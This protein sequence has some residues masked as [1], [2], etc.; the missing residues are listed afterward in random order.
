MNTNQLKKFAKAARIRLLGDVKNRFLYWGIAKDGTV[1]HQVDTT[2]G[3]YEFRGNVFNDESVPKKWDKLLSAVK[4]HPPN[5]IIEEAAYTWF[6]RLISIKILEEN[7]YDDPIIS[8]VSSDLH[9]P[10]ILR[11]AKRG[12]TPDMSEQSKR[13]LD[14]YIND[15]NDDEALSLLLI[16]YCKNHKLLNRLFGRIDDYTELL[17]PNNLLAKDGIIS[18]IN[19]TDYITEEDFQQV[20]LIG[21]LYQFYISDK[22]DDVF[23]SFKKKQKARAE[24]IPAATQIFTPKWIV[25]YLI[26]NTVGR[27]WLDKHSDS[28]I[29]NTMKYLVEPE[30]AKP[31]EP[32]IDNVSELKVLDPA[33]GSGHFLVVAFDLLMQAYKEEGYTNRYAVES[34]IK[35]NL[36]GL[37]LCKRAVGL[38]NFAILLKG[39]SYYPEILQKDV[40]QHIFAMP[41]Q[42]EFSKQQVFDFLGEEGR[43]YVD[44]LETALE[45]MQLAQ[46]IGS[47]LVIELSNDT[48]EFIQNRFGDFTRR[49]I[50]NEF[51]LFE[52]S[53]F[54]NIKSFIQ[55]IL[56][57]TDKYPAVV[58]NPP[59]M[60]SKNMNIELSDYL[61]SHYPKSKA[62]LFAVFM[63]VLPN[64]TL[65]GGGFGFIT[66]PSW[67]FLITYGKLREHYL[68]NYY[69]KSLLHLSRGVFGAD[70]GAVATALEK[71]PS[72]NRTGDYLRLIERT[73]QEFETEHLH[74]LLSNVLNNH[75]FK[76]DFGKYT[77][78]SGIPTQS[79]P[80]GKQIYYTQIP[81]TNFSKIPGSPIAYWVSERVIE[82][83]DNKS[84]N[85]FVET[86]LGMATGSNKIFLRDWSEVD[87]TKINLNCDNRVS[88]IESEKKWY[89]YSKG[90]QYRKWYGNQE[91]LVNWQNDGKDLRNFATSTGRIRSHNYNLDYIFKNGITW[92][93]LSSG[94]PSMR[95]LNSSLF[96]NAG[97]SLFSDSVSRNVL[98]GYLNTNLIP[99]FQNI[100]SSTFNYQ[101]GDIAKLPYKPILNSKNIDVVVGSSINLSKSDWDSRETSWDFKKLPLLNNS[102]SLPKSY[103]SWEEKVTEDFFKL[104]E[105]EEE[106]NRIFIDIYALQDEL[107][108]DVALKDITILQE[109]LD[110][111]QLKIDNGK[112]IMDSSTTLT[113]QRKLPIKKDVVIKQLLS[114]ATGCFMGRYRL[115]KPGLNIAH[116]NPSSEELSS[117]THN[118]NQ[119]EIDDDGII[120][121]MGSESP[122][123][124]DI[125]FRTKEF[126]RM[127]WSD[128]SFTEN[129]NFINECLGEDLEKYLTKKF[130]NDHKKTYKKKPIYWQFSSPQD[131]FKVICYMHRMNRFTVQ[132]IRQNYLFKQINWYE[133]EISQLSKNEA[134]LTSKES[135]Q[136]D[137]F[138]K[139]LVEC[140]EYDLLLKD[141]ADKQIEF[142]LD[143]GV[144]ENYKL[145]DGVVSK[146]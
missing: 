55:S 10:I 120:P 33:V 122:F 17:L 114:Y 144:T 125:V 102:S 127:V 70:F 2:S 42:F 85:E 104:H 24:D 116:P 88:A 141:A 145:F 35:N 63:E 77:K 49:E 136:L 52:A 78:E 123:A 101:P 133:R 27:I 4:L 22:K 81:Q 13:Q 56:I 142:D 92:N 129:L 75:D 121:T 106:L 21:W 48:R 32:I 45:Q 3:G 110:R 96:D 137:N 1:I 59:Y 99:L 126:V 46:N 53:L 67:M 80:N 98:L 41:E 134:R 28:P 19:N 112:L 26:E 132:K 71:N 74:Q 62:D 146:I 89:P 139:N 40:A 83:F 18:L 140:R 43:Q 58:A 119:F 68:D 113:E 84:I 109:E 6:N 61:K 91:T 130:W 14:E 143:D 64:L 36:Y 15:S 60:G 100:I 12:N 8:Y 79:D 57:L 103:S 115:D 44:E 118:G 86:R 108:P 69:Y 54:N 95:I 93:A 94:N 51:N 97:S 90:G 124:D 105:N 7:G 39:A 73:F 34:I 38:A 25:K 20:E 23:A 31:S 87:Y 82:V 111:N 135:R 76:F 138:R 47:A 131:A 72:K 50:Q 11:E 128:K 37:D 117:Y 107:T 66:T 29:R 5:D 30:N 16:H 65:K 9:D